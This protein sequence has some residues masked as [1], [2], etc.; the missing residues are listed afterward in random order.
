MADEMNKHATPWN[1][2]PEAFT[3][4]QK[5]EVE[6]AVHNLKN[7]APSNTLHSAWTITLARKAAK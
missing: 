4:Y 1:P 7:N 2:T 5:R 3:A 6:L